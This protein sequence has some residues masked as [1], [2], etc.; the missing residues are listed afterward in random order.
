MPY[1]EE[2]NTRRE[3]SLIPN[4]QIESMFM[5]I[6]SDEEMAQYLK[7]VEQGHISLATAYASNS[8]YKLF[9]KLVE[10]YDRRGGNLEM[11]KEG[12]TK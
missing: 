8:V 7:L 10:Y 1:E 12:K 3:D 5:R 9:Y 11:L 2:K 4:T 6:C